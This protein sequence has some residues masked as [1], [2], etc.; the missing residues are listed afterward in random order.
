MKTTLLYI[1][2]VLTTATFA[3]SAAD[4]T[5]LNQAVQP[6]AIVMTNFT[7]NYHTKAIWTANEDN[8]FNGSYTDES[9]NMGRVII[10][11]QRGNLIAVQNELHNNAYPAAIA[12]WYIKNYPR[13]KFVIWSNYD[14]NDTKTY[15]ANRAQET[16]WFDRNGTYTHS[17]KKGSQLITK[18]S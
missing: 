7:A 3:Q 13:E 18:K 2:L 10:Y 11:D 12:T 15:F 16:I 5:G 14:T 1:F 9:T 4:P 17:A 6:P 8:T